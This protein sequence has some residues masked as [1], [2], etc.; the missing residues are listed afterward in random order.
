MLSI[1]YVSRACG[2]LARYGLQLLARYRLYVWI[3][4]SFMAVRPS[5]QQCDRKDNESRTRMNWSRRVLF[6][7]K[8]EIISVHNLILSA[9]HELRGIPGYYVCSFRLSPTRLRISDYYSY[10]SQKLLTHLSHRFPSIHPAFVFPNAENRE[11]PASTRVLFNSGIYRLEM[12]SSIW[13]IDSHRS[14]GITIFGSFSVL[15]CGYL[16]ESGGYWEISYLHVAVR[17]VVP[18]FW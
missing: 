5:L 2:M 7:H 11:E 17:V 18:R 13:A 8:E 16:P 1:I 12:G 15:T 9:R 10:P 3:E 6:W 4:L 14:H